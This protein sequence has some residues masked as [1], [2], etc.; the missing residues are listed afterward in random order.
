MAI[1]EKYRLY[2]LCA[3]MYTSLNSDNV[4][5]HDQSNN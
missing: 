3:G 1:K 5:T 4:V 2:I